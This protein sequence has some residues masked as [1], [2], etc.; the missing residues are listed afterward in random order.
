[1]ILP[2]TSPGS[3]TSHSMQ[4]PRSSRTGCWRSASKRTILVGK[5]AG[6]HQG[7][8]PTAPL[9]PVE[10]EQR[11]VAFGRGIKLDDLRNLEAPLELRPNVWPQAV[12]A[13]QAQVVRALFRVRRRVDEITAELADILEAGTIPAHDVVP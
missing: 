4:K 10:M 1:M 9:L 6:T 12:A 3:S 2:M 5:R 8:R 13:G 11:P 7:S